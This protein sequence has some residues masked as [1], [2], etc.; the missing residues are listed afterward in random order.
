MK[1][2]NYKPRREGKPKRK[3]KISKLKS[4]MLVETKE[5]KPITSS[6]L[7]EAYS[8]KI[9]WARELIPKLET[10]AAKKKE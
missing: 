2:E 6:K 5:R 9:E 10:E 4:R 8:T 3:G 1:P 7:S